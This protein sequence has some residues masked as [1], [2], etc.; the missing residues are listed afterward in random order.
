MQ[1]RRFLR[2]TQATVNQWQAEQF[3]AARSAGV[4]NH[5]REEFREFLDA[6][7]DAEA[8]EEAADIVILL[9][10]W[11]S[12]TSFDLHA[13]IDRKMARNRARS[14]NILFDGTGRHV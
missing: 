2:E 6:P 10:F 12:L 1:Y 8:A 4:V 3:P 7:S 5:L 14:W 11:A 9:Y 13:E